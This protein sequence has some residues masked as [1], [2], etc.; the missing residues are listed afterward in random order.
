MFLFYQR[1]VV[2][3]NGFMNKNLLNELEILAALSNP[4]IVKMIDSFH[5]N[6]RLGI[7]IEYCQVILFCMF[8]F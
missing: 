7:V 1:V 4:F 6:A 2:K 3:S 5:I 8:V